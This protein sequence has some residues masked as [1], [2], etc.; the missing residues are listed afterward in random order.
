MTAQFFQQQLDYIFFLYG[1]AF[2][3]LA[4]VC[5]IMHRERIGQ[6]PWIWLGL[7]GLVHGITEWLDMVALSLGDGTAFS[8]VRLGLMTLSFVFLFEFGRDGLI[9]LQGNGPGRW[10]YV[11]LLAFAISGGFAGLSGLNAV[12]RYTFGLSGALLSGLSLLRASRMKNSTRHALFFAAVLMAGYALVAGGIVPAA[13]FFPASVINQASFLS[14][15]GIPIQLIRGILAVL[16]ATSFWWYYLRHREFVL[17]AVIQRTKA[18]Y[19]LQFSLLIVIVLTLGWM[20][21]EFVGKDAEQD[22]L[23][24]IKN[25]TNVAAASLDPARVRHLAPDP[26][27]STDPDYIRLKEQLRDMKSGNPEF[28]RL[29]L[30]YLKG[31]NYI[32]VAVSSPQNEYGHAMPG[33]R[34]YERPSVELSEVF[35]SGQAVVVGPYAVEY[36]TFL[37][38]FA[39]VLD[40]LSRRTI[41]VLGI[42]LNAGY[43]KKKIAKQRV[44]P[45]L[46]TL[47]IS[48]LCVG[49]F[50]VRQRLWETA[51]RIAVSEKTLTE[52]QKIAHLGSW[53]YDPR[54]DVLTWLRRC[55][56]SSGLILGAAF[57]QCPGSS[58][59][60]TRKT[61]INWMKP[62]RRR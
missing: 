1:F 49:F 4:A 55:L 14:L 20:L 39:P 23:N 10:I 58:S 42:D 37:S 22:A 43:L 50:V 5:L 30:M 25:Q 11:P 34:P 54:T 35:T 28:L 31:G 8:A 56:I 32:F 62:F 9:K 27:D 47:L 21:T 6:L 16:I 13:S 38:G 29:Y 15:T 51:Q 18:R 17:P 3:L 36:G 46:V 52:A 24:D 40:T 44:P 61:G 41:G 12:V 45:I 59:S 2:I 53:T 19:G 26:F 33:K 48:L 7:F 57:L 60:S